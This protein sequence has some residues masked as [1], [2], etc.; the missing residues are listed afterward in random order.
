M[1]RPILVILLLNLPFLAKADEAR[2]FRLAADEALI[3]TGLLAYLLPRFSLKT[4]RRA[5]IGGE[6]ADL[7]LSPSADGA[8]AFT[9][10][11]TVYYF[12]LLTD[13]PAARIFTEWLLSEGG[14]NTIAA[15]Q[16][17][18]GGP[19]FQPPA[20]QVERETALFEGDAAAGAVL[21]AQHCGRC[22]RV[23]G[24][25]D[26]MGIG[27]TPSFRA[28]RSL[29]DW[30]ERLMAFYALNPHPAFLRVEEISPDF[31]PD[32]PP[33]IVPIV[34]TLDEAE[35]IQAYVASLEPADLGAEI[36]HQ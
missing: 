5:E 10:G 29:S 36:Q 32:A 7:R 18:D 12:E 8:S 28:L 16:P 23:G 35:A 27:S 22:H 26:S 33:P 2:S 25:Q 6:A 9:R 34:L 20:P 3:E 11:E 4:A 24:A 1:L 30:P 15:F 21:A 31:S 14:A 13:H 17:S 19:T